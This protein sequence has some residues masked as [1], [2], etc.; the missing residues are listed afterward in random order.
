MPLYLC[1]YEWYIWTLY[2]V[3]KTWW[4]TYRF[5]GHST[6]RTAASQV[7]MDWSRVSQDE[8]CVNTLNVGV[9]MSTIDEVSGESARK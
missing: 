6:A 5:P 4:R 3:F 9:N 8:S 7:E 2:G 1:T